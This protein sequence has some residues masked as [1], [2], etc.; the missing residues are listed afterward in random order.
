[1]PTKRAVRLPQQSPIHEFNSDK[2]QH[3][4]VVFR[5]GIPEKSEW[6]EYRDVG[7]FKGYSFCALANIPGVPLGIFKAVP[8]TYE[9]LE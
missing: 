9:V 4:I 1:M 3:R 6:F 2:R 5:A 8:V 7:F